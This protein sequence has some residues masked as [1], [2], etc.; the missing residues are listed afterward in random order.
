[1]IETP[2]LSPQ[3]RSAHDVAKAIVGLPWKVDNIII[4]EVVKG[5][6]DGFD[7]VCRVKFYRKEAN[8]VKF[9]NMPFSEQE[10]PESRDYRMKYASWDRIFDAGLRIKGMSNAI[11]IA[12]GEN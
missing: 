4:G 6:V 5:W 2:K 11:R 9:E 1:M 3:G 10:L 7:V 8:R 12:N